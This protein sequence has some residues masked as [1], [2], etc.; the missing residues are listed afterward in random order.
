M[1]PDMEEDMNKKGE[2][3]LSGDNAFKLY[4]TYR[5]T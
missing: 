1:I 4:D 5:S 2:K 3:V